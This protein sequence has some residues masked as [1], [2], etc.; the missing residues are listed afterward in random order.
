MSVLR[1]ICVHALLIGI[2]TVVGCSKQLPIAEV[3]GIVTLKGKPLDK[4]QVEFWPV[5]EGTRSIGT[6]DADGKFQLMTDD[7]LRKGASIGEHKIVLHDTSV[8][9]DKF[10]GRAG[11]NVDM[12][13]GRKSRISGSYS[14]PESSKLTFEVKA[15]KKNEFPIEIQK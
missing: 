13:E 4:I 11:E 9:G 8:L 15:G 10:L 5:S 12:S 7:G 6:T 1:T 14:N 2:P 3:E